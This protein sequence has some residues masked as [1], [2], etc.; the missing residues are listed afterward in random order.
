MQCTKWSNM[1]SYLETELW[2]IAKHLFWP[3]KGI[4]GCDET[5]PTMGKRFRVKFHY[6][7]R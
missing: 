4:M 3:G 7:H 1:P 2:K 5:V 6:P